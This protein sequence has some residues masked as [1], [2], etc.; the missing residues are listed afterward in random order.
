M[1]DY[2]VSLIRTWVPVGV[3]AAVTWLA[4]TLGIVLDD[5]TSKGLLVVSTAVVIAVYYAAAR[6]VEKRYPGFGRV[7]VALGLAGKPVYPE[8]DRM[9]SR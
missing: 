6:L 5:E 4:A 8:T 2:F 1:N 9:P 7:L 3:G